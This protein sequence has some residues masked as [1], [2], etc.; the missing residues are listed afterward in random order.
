M[1][2]KTLPFRGHSYQIA[3]ENASD[4]TFQHPSWFSFEDE[5]DVRDRAWHI[6]PGD[7][8]LD[9]GAAY[10]SYALTA[11]ACGA[12][13]A[14]AWSPQGPPDGTSEADMLR[15]SLELNGWLDRCTIFRQGCFDRRGWVNALTQEFAAD[16]PAAM[17]GDVIEVTPVD[18]FLAHHSQCEK[19]GPTPRRVW[20][21]LDVEGAEIEVLKGAARTIAAYRPRIL[22]ENHNFKRATIEQEVRDLMTSMRYREVETVPYH[23]VSH[24]VYEPA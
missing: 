15:R 8:I 13:Y 10:G 3:Y 4:P 22:V 11:L 6:E 20:M 17:T 19:F 7:V 2:A 9:V 21:K 1:N 18:G 5:S 14:F 24:S 12:K 16:K 23:S